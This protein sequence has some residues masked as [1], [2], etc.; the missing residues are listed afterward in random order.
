[1]DDQD[2]E[3]DAI[4]SASTHPEAASGPV[5]ETPTETVMPLVSPAPT[6]PVVRRPNRR[7]RRVALVAA[8]VVVALT[9]TGA[10]AASFALATPTSTAPAVL[11]WTPPD[12]VAYV[13]ARLDLPG[14]QRDAL[15][16]FLRAFPGGDDPNLLGSTLTG[17]LDRL[18]DKAS[19]SK[20]SYSAD[21]AP[22]FG[23]QVSLS[24]GPLPDAASVKD[25]TARPRVLGLVSVTDAAKADAWVDKV[26]DEAGASALVTKETVGGVEMVVGPESHG[27]QPAYAVPGPVLAIGDV[28]SVRAAILT[29]GVHGLGGDEAFRSASSGLDG[30]RVAYM[31]AKI[32]DLFDWSTAFGTGFRTGA[33]TAPPSLSP[34]LR[35][36]LPKWEAVALRADQG[37]VADARVD[38]TGMAATANAASRLANRVPSSA[39]VFAEAHDVGASYLRL[40]DAYRSDPAMADGIRKIDQALNLVGGSQGTLGWIGDT[41]LVALRDGPSVSGGVVV[42]TTDR[43]AAERLLTT[44]RSYATVSGNSLGIT[45]R[46]EPHGSSTITVIDLGD[47]RARFAASGASAKIADRLPTGH[48][49]LAYTV[50]DDLVVIG[51]GPGFVGQILD[52]QPGSSLADAPRFASLV[53][54]V[55]HEN[56]GL[57][58][59]DLAAVRG[60]VEA[61]IPAEMRGRYDATVGPFLAPLDTLVAGTVAGQAADQSKVVLTVAGGR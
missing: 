31:Y 53:D 45:V 41:A 13:E 33:S 26:I 24:V 35:G 22:W 21:I 49:E 14:G 16:S 27:V 29:A 32:G 44:L 12:S 50:T 56:A 19:R 54:R 11:A 58:W 5:D 59:V 34:A 46:D 37:L 60:V 57:T 1:M 30:D 36:L 25:G 38:H 3:Q 7:P 2:G 55:G 61:A 43:T 48:V 4:T 23:G 6:Q 8:L 10:A 18:V 9:I 40:L 28:A 51:S 15:A 20:V 39:I 42:A 17:A 52:T 47:L